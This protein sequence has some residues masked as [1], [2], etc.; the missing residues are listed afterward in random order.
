MLLSASGDF[1]IAPGLPKA[2]TAE[3]D[4]LHAQQR[5]P[6]Q[7]ARGTPTILQQE[8]RSMREMKDLLTILWQGTVR[9]GRELSTTGRGEIPKQKREKS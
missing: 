9:A 8:R 2:C 7:N 6:D 4:G 5:S 3:A 1:T